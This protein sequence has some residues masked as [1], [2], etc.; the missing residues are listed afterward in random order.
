DY[1]LRGEFPY[2]VSKSCADLI[3]SMYAR[4]FRLPVA[5]ARCG[6]LFGG[7]DLNFSR[8]IPGL[9]RDTVAGRP[10]L[11]PRGGRS[12]TRGTAGCVRNSLYVEDAAEASLL[13]AERLAADEALRGEAFNFGLG[14]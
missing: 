8:L 11:I 5:V 2:E 6:N 1:P 7:G 14:L 10:V 3:A 13:R 9:I 12:R 4:T